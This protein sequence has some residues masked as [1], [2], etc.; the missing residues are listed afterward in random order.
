MRVLP[1]S[2]LMFHG[3][4]AQ[5][6]L[7]LRPGFGNAAA[8]MLT[9]VKQRQVAFLNLRRPPRRKNSAESNSAA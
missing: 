2:R 7:L 4:A 9:G 6:E 8:T 1:V 5:F 3:L